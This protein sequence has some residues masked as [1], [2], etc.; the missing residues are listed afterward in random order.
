MKETA[1]SFN[2]VEY[3]STS[4]PGERAIEVPIAKPFLDRFSEDEYFEVGFVMFGQRGYFDRD[5]THLVIDKY[6]MHDD[7]ENLLNIDIVDFLEVREYKGCFS[8]STIEHVGR[9]E[10]G[11]NDWDKPLLALE[12]MRKAVC[13]NGFMF[14]TIPLG[15][16]KKLDEHITSGRMCFDEMYYMKQIESRVWEQV[17]ASDVI[18]AEYHRPFPAANAL[19]IGIDN[20]RIFQS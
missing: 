7:Y 4:A 18:G 20:E 17:D 1:F 12:I 9:D 2:G 5:I 14:V 6:E 15:Y 10:D 16:N 13:K 3:M 19:L 11:P 8:I